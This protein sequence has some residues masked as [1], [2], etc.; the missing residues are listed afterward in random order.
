VLPPGQPAIKPQAEIYVQPPRHVTAPAAQTPVAASPQLSNHSAVL[1]PAG[2]P[3]PMP[4]TPV[5]AV[6]AS[7]AP[8]MIQVAPAVAAPGVLPVQI[9]P[10]ER[11]QARP[12][13]DADTAKGGKAGDRNPVAVP[14]NKP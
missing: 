2:L 6:R 10:A 7:P 8:T 12:A 4:A 1:G 3:L 9:A 14:V 13:A 5:P 11:P